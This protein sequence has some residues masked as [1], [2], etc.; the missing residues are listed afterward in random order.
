M[1][2]FECLFWSVIV[3]LSWTFLAFPLLTVTLGWRARRSD[4]G[5]AV[6]SSVSIVMA[7]HNE[8]S[9]IA[10]KLHHLLAFSDDYERFEIVVVSDG[11]TD[12]TE[13]IA[14][15]FESERVRVLASPRW[16]GKNRALDEGVK[17]A[18]GEILVFMDVS[19]R[20]RPGCLEKLL[21]PF[22]D[23]RVGCVGGHVFYAAS[24]RERGAFRAFKW[25]D[26]YMKLGES[27]MGFV[28]AVSGAIHALRSPIYQPT[29]PS[30]TR[31]VVDPVQAVREGYRV[32][33][34][35][36]AILVEPEQDPAP[37]LFSARA[38]MTARGMSSSATAL[39]ELRAARSA[40]AIGIF[41]SHKLLRWWLWLPMLAVL[42]SSIALASSSPFYA[43]V[44]GAQ[45]L[46]YGL[47]ALGLILRDRSPGVLLGPAF[48]L[49]QSGAMLAGTWSWV[50]GR[51][52]ENWV[53]GTGHP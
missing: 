51:E 34:A 42:S 23:P 22:S 33:Y 32:V 27:A 46:G 10:E 53:R 52:R 45:C 15:S 14:R 40:T 6:P 36:D 43:A 41:A 2:L 26:R 44:A 49:L 25:V 16:L 28:P 30:S 18:T 8:D 1:L 7:A 19:G 5:G 37:M 39:R 29:A 38:R 20:L 4:P 11:S 21:A 50:M 17:L 13:V 3:L 48:L 12:R 47:G 35:A 24:G 9:C 31:D